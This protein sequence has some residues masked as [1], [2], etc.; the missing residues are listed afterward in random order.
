MDKLLYVK[1]T[2]QTILDNRKKSRPGLQPGSLKRLGRPG[3]FPASLI[4][5]FRK[6]KT[7]KFL[8]V[9]SLTSCSNLLSLS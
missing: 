3:R 5:L 2:Y 7:E 6:G 4:K 9:T 8:S 1:P